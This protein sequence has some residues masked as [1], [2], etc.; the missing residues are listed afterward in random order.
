M[1]GVKRQS[2]IKQGIIKQLVELFIFPLFKYKPR[3]KH[4]LDFIDEIWCSDTRTIE[5]YMARKDFYM[6]GSYWKL[7]HKLPTYG[8]RKVKAGTT[9]FIRIDTV[10]NQI[11]IEIQMPPNNEWQ[12]FTVTEEQY[13]KIKDRL[14]LLPYLRRRYRRTHSWAKNLLK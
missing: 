1:A 12:V 5:R 3:N 7:P 13:D 4:L 9:M 14:K 10:L 8:E 11:D 2:P 6:P